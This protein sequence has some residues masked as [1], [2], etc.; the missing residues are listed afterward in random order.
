M[1]AFLLVSLKQRLSFAIRRLKRGATSLLASPPCASLHSKELAER[2]NVV[3]CIPFMG[4][5]LGG[6]A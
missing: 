6:K 5:L 1:L 4:E 2:G 3:T